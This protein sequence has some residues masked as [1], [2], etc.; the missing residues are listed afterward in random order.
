[1]AAKKKRR[2]AAKP[3]PAAPEGMLPLKCCGYA[4]GK[5]RL[6]TRLKTHGHGG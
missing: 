5:H 4:I 6:Y 1:M 2:G 3:A